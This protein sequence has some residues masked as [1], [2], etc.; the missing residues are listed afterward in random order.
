M[1]I[2]SA[3]SIR[4]RCTQEEMIF[5]FHLRSEFDGLT[6]GVG[7]AGYDICVALPNP[8]RMLIEGYYS[9]YPGFHI[10]SAREFFRIPRD[11]QAV[12]HDKSTWARRGVCVQNTIVDPGFR[13]Y[14]TLEITNHS[15]ELYTVREGTPIAQIVFHKLDEP[16]DS[17]YDGKYQDQESGPQEAR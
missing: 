12:V 16:T 17:P 8:A 5:P 11:I 14:L 6:Y 13:G 1:T 3:Q 15:N 9:I 2:L 7:P 4:R 10:L